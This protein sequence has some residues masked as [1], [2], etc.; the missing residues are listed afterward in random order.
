LAAV[1]LKNSL[2]SNAL[3][4]KVPAMR[5]VIVGLLGFIAGGLLGGLI[6]TLLVKGDLASAGGWTLIFCVVSCVALHPY[7]VQES[8]QNLV[9]QKAHQIFSKLIQ[10]R[11]FYAS[12]SFTTLPA[13]SVNR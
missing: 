2:Q 11:Q 5:S 13:T 3:N 8:A 6:T 12:T 7:S 10:K 1:F 4:K 9:V